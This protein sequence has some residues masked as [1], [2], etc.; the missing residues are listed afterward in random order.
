MTWHTT[1]RTTDKQAC[2]FIHK[3][4]QNTTSTART[5]PTTNK[6]FKYQRLPPSYLCADSA[7]THRRAIMK[8]TSA[9]SPPSVPDSARRMS[10]VFN[11]SNNS[12]GHWL[13]MSP[14]PTTTTQHNTTHSCVSCI[15]GNKTQFRTHQSPSRTLW[16][17]Q[18][19]PACARWTWTLGPDR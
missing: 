3:Q 2:T 16:H 12:G 8:Y 17:S 14:A 9:G 19:T 18:L 6:N 13:R 4:Q 5:T 7:H 10:L 11:S 1:M 15:L